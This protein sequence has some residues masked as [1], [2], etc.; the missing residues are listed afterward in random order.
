MCL[1][2][3]S[4]LTCLYIWLYST[5]NKMEVL[6]ISQYAQLI[7]YQYCDLQWLTENKV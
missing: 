3:F 7:Y 4:N 2:V 6:L 5:A 1:N